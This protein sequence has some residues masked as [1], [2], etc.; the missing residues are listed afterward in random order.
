MSGPTLLMCP[1]CCPF[2]NAPLSITG[3][4]ERICI[5]WFQFSICFMQFLWKWCYFRWAFRSEAKW[6]TS[7]A[8]QWVIV[9]YWTITNWWWIWCFR[10]DY[11]CQTTLS[12]VAVPWTQPLTE[13]EEPDQ[14]FFCSCLCWAACLVLERQ[15][16]LLAY[17]YRIPPE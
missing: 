10:S 16:L 6:N 11:F 2:R 4:V 5:D 12:A 7:G 17:L 13:A 1:F 8:L 9:L 15:W 3:L 14:C